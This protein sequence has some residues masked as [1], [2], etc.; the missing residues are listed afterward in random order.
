MYSCCILI[1][2]MPP[3]T[4]GVNFSA[5]GKLDEAIKSCKKV[6]SLI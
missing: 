3:A 5:E 1:M 4:L 6:I 2:L